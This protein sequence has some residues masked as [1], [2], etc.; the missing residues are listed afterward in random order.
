MV[1]DVNATVDWL[2]NHSAVK[3][4]GI[5][6]VGFCMGGRVAWLAAA[7][8]PHIKA[9]VP[10][11]G[12]RIMVAKG[13]EKSPFELSQGIQC[14]MLFHFGEIDQTPSLDEMRK[15]DVELTRLGKTHQFYTYAGANHAF[16]DPSDDRYHRE[17]DERS[18]P[19][20][21]DFFASH[22]RGAAV[23]R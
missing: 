10:Y 19:R 22:L 6:I 2:R 21:L 16:M 9:T 12:G 23:A 4:E 3:K 13:A 1:A 14:P 15:M 20:T 5:G 11:Y 17:A 8:N 18:W 7:T